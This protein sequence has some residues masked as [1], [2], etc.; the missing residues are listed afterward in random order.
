M[1]R[2]PLLEIR[3]LRTSFLVGDRQVAAVEG[4]NLR[5]DRGETVGLVGES[6]SGKSI[7]ALS[8]LRL[9]PQP[10]QITDG[11]IIFEGE[12]LLKLPESNMRHIRG[13][14]I[15]MVFQEPM[16]SLNPVY[17]IGDQIV[18]AVV[19]HQKKSRKEAIVET[20]SLLGLVGIP[21]PERRMHNYPHELSGGLQQRA[22]IAMALACRPKLLIADEPTTALDVTIQAQILELLK[23]LRDE[24]GMAILLITHAMGV[25]AEM[26]ERVAVMYAGKIV[27][28]APVA[29]LFHDP[30]H[31]YT[32]GLLES[33]PRLDAPRERLH[34]IDGVVPSLGNMPA[35]CRF[36]PRCPL[37]QDRCR[38]DEPPLVET[39]AGRRV[40]CWLH[41]A[42]R[43]GR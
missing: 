36:H 4:V 26:A 35:G 2:G 34:A 38:Q 22:M 21:S 19:L 31:P 29:A 9:V 41:A 43:E 20:V 15:S 6:G 5:I 39:S 18:E 33:I 27:E 28:E 13:N 40:S 25:V 16:T 7:T 32:K 23:R 30:L 8:I 1:N 11:E 42:Q 12:D 24:L 10:G 14:E 37:A 17:T 3:N